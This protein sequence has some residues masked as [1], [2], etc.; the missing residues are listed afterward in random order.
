MNAT[1]RPTSR[2][3]A[4][5]STAGTDP[6]RWTDEDV[7]RLIALKLSICRWEKP[8]ETLRLYG[9]TQRLSAMRMRLDGSANGHRCQPQIERMPALCAAQLA[10]LYTAIRRVLDGE[11]DAFKAFG[12]AVP[13]RNPG[14]PRTPFM[15]AECE[16]GRRLA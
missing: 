6:V 8:E 14:N 3:R 10:F 5:S 1:A 13:D 2:K 15:A 16:L 7:E 4:I 11:R 12:L 9:I